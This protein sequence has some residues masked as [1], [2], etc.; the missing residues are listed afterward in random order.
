MHTI[1]NRRIL[2]KLSVVLVL[3]VALFSTGFSSAFAAALPATS[4]CTGAGTGTVTCSLW[5]KTG[6]ATIYGATTVNIWGYSASSVG[7]AGLP[8]PLLLVNEGDMVTVILTNTLTESTA[9]LFQGQS[10][11]PDLTGVAAGGSKSYTFQATT[12]GTYLYEAGLVSNG[13]HQVA[14]GLYGALVVLPAA[15]PTYNEETLLVLSEYD[16]ALALSPATFD[17]RKYHP[18]YFLINGKAYPDTA[19]IP[20]TAGNSVLLRYVNAGLQVHSMGL[21][22]LSQTLVATD[23]NPF[24]RTHQVVAESIAPG[25]TLDA[26]ITIPMVADGSKFA[27]FDS[28]MSLRNTNAGGLGGMLTFLAVGGVPPVGDTTGPTTSGVALTPNL[29]TGAAN[30]SISASVSDAASNVSAAEFFIDVTGANGTGTAMSGSFG[31][32]TAAVSGSFS[33][34]GLSTGSH[35]IYVHGQDSVGNWGAFSS[36]VL[37][38]DNTGPTTSALTLSPNPSNGTVAVTLNA[39]ANDTASGGS[40]I[41]AATYSIDGG[42]AIAMTLSTTSAPIASLSATIPVSTLSG[43]ASGLHTVSVTSQDAMGLWGAPAT[44]NLSIDQ[45]GP[46]TSGVV[47]APNPNNGAYPL[48]TSTPVVR[49]TASF[50]DVASG[51]SNI[52]AAEGFLDTVGANGTGLFFGA[53]DGVFNSPAESGFGDFPLPVINTLSEGVHTIY[54]HAKDASGVWGAMSTTTLTIEKTAPTLTSISV[55]P[56]PTN[57]APFVAVTLTGATDPVGLTPPTGL[58][59]GEYWFGTTAPALGAGTPFSGL[60][61]SIP[62]SS[63]ASGTYTLN[64]RVRDAAFNWSPYRSATLIVWANSIFSN[65]FETGNTNG[66]SSSSTTLANRMNVSAGAAMVGSFGLQA[67]GNNTNYVQYN[68]GTAANPVAPTFDARFYFNPNGNTNGAHN[69]FSAATA[70]NFNTVLF[71]VRY[72]M[73]AG[74]SQVQIQ[75]GT[76][77]SNAAWVNINNAANN[78]IE[79]VWQAV[80][81]SGPNPGSLRL[82]VNGAL[83]QT[84]ATTSTSSV[85]S[86]RLGSVSSGTS[87]IFEYLDAFVAKRQTSPLVGP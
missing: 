3:V 53:T 63:L 55:S 87:S 21:I 62:V 36:A 33:A 8:G 25:Q 59:G 9:L 23:G 29:V 51:N 74:Q 68:F 79:V 32:P 30:V 28:S 42:P 15:A 19:S 44:I 12:P 61:P 49:V 40:N 78:V 82:Y 18:Q 64:V 76:L 20:V 41:A 52:V 31:S 39:T 45:G 10:M 80:G 56:S 81:S 1:T 37:K 72:R 86:F 2:E 77:N 46:T 34:T 7:P 65:S 73:N 47:A 58:T 16:P 4:A 5:A 83:A 48:N 26:L 57:G 71:R 14:M 69:I 6:T 75:V 17:M 60:A 66:W 13:Q 27:L 54:V 43:L 67:R 50:S 35:N 11:I 38:V 84:L 70:A 85:G 22:G 24:S